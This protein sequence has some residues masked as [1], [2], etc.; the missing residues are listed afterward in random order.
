MKIFDPDYWSRSMRD[1]LVLAGLVVDLAPIYAV[2]AWGWGAGALVGLY[3]I[4]NVIIGAATLPRIFVSAARQGVTG[5]LGGAF[6]GAFFTVHYGMFCFVHG[7]FV[8]SF[9]AMS[10]GAGGEAFPDGP[11]ELIGRATGMAPHMLLM[12]LLL[13]AWQAVLLVWEFGVKGGWRT[14]NPNEEMMAPYGRIVVLHVGIFAG[15][16]ALIFV[17]DP[18]IG[19]LGLILLRA[20]WGVWTRSRL[21]RKAADELSVEAAAS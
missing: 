15:A 3:W 18:M 19:V 9:F 14:S 1:P 17:G 8:M 5:V 11:L 6:L 2:L 7:V 4:E 16:A 10:S 12:A 13:A 20:L 21:S